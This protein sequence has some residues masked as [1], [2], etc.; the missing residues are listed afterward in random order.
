MTT[1]R[2]TW[3]QRE[4]QTAKLFGTKRNP[5]SGTQGRSDC[6]SASGSVHPVLFIECKLRAKH[7]VVTLWD[8]TKVKAKKEKKI[9]VVSLSEKG[10]PG[11]W[12]LVHSDD[13][14]AVA[15]EMVEDE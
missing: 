9:P 3:K 14:K 12:I 4:R 10:R 5:G 1:H 7:T 13:L 15:R 2:N 8:D 11:S 6:K